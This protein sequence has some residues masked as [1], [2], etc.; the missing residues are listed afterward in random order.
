MENAVAEEESSDNAEDIVDLNHKRKK[1]YFN[2]AFDIKLIRAVINENPYDPVK[3][4]TAAWAA[5]AAAIDQECGTEG[6]LPRTC[7]DRTERLLAYFEQDHPFLKGTDTNGEKQQRL[8]YLEDL[9]SLKK[10]WSK[11]TGEGTTQQ[12]RKIRLHGS[13]PPRRLVPRTLSAGSTTTA[14]YSTTGSGNG[15]G[16]VDDRTATSYWVTSGKF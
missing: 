7:R 8:S 4:R 12:A 6:L 13:V 10:T 3:D 2:P 16:T 9:S 5:I 15:S 11:A 14:T 1:V